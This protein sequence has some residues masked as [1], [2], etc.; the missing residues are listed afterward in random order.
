MAQWHLQQQRCRQH[1]IQSQAWV[2]PA[3]HKQVQQFPSLVCWARR[4]PAS[5]AAHRQ[6]QHPAAQPAATG[7]ST[8]RSSR[9]KRQCTSCCCSTHSST[10]RTGQ[11]SS[12]SPSG[13]STAGLAHATA[14]C[15]AG[16][17]QRPY[18]APVDHETDRAVHGVQHEQQRVRASHSTCAGCEQRY[19][20]RPC[21][22]STVHV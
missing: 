6:P 16:R 21:M 4:R 13:P 9:A 11:H 8:S 12:S 20:A 1:S 3:T 18:F 10:C 17:D 22:C 7:R 5:Q 19:E 14:R 15:P 2:G